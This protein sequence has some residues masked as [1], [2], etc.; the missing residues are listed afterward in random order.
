MILDGCAGMTGMNFLGRELE[1]IE[2]AIAEQ[3]RIRHEGPDGTPPA[4]AL[5]YRRFA[6]GEIGRALAEAR[7]LFASPAPSSVR[8]SFAHPIAA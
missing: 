4:V 7:E 1:E 8:S 6:E 5:A 3:V 2:D